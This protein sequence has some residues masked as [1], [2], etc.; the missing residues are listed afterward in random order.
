MISKPVLGTNPAIFR[1]DLCPK[2]LSKSVLN[3][4]YR[5]IQEFTQISLIFRSE[6]FSTLLKTG[7]GHK[8][9]T[10]STVFQPQRHNFLEIYYLNRSY[11]PFCIVHSMWYCSI[12]KNSL[13]KQFWAQIRPLSRRSSNRVFDFLAHLSTWKLRQDNCRYFFCNANRF[14][15]RFTVFGH[16]S[17]PKYRN[18]C[19]FSNLETP[20]DIF[21]C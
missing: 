19:V 16:K 12:P 8:S 5:N 13:E 21:G 10:F 15:N 11:D 9:G 20:E 14:Q 7:F 1:P 17:G 6:I 4:L 2:P 18:I 3:I